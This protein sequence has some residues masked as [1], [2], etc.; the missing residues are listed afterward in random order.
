MGNVISYCTA[1]ADASAK[2]GKFLRSGEKYSR[3]IAVTH[4]A[5]LLV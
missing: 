5:E 4:S 3:K 2:S 1:K